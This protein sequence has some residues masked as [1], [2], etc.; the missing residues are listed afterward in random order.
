MGEFHDRYTASRKALIEDTKLDIQ[1]ADSED[2]LAIDTLNQQ[3]GQR[4]KPVVR[5]QGSVLEGINNCESLLHPGP[6]RHGP[7]TRGPGVGEGELQLGND[8]QKA[9]DF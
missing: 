6:A 5:G 7:V 3:L 1:V 9:I 2:P 8:V 4:L